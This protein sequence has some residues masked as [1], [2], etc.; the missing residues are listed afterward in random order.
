MIYSYDPNWF[1]SA[2]PTTMTP[3]EIFDELYGE[4]SRY[5]PYNPNYRWGQ[6]N[7]T[8]IPTTTNDLYQTITRTT[9]TTLGRGITT[10]GTIPLYQSIIYEDENG[11]LHGF[12][13]DG[14]DLIMDADDWY[15]IV[16]GGAMI[17]DGVTVEIKN[18][19][20]IVSGREGIGRVLSGLKGRVYSVN[21]PL[22]QE[23]STAKG[24]MK[25]QLG[26][27]YLTGGAIAVYDVIK[28]ANNEYNSSIDFTADLLRDETIV[29]TSGG[30]GIL[31]TGGITALCG[32]IGGT[33][34]T[35]AGP[36]GI[37]GGAGIGLGVGYVI[38]R[39]SDQI[40]NFWKG[41]VSGAE[42]AI[43]RL[44]SLVNSTMSYIMSKIYEEYGDDLGGIHEG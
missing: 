1:N 24:A 7:S 5:N 39:F 35:L 21:N 29:I 26:G 18:G 42:N 38:S 32:K 19:K 28:A 4:D 14:K 13:Y 23:F 22:I 6:S 10:T 8:T 27:L 17:A 12:I 44:D 15:E 25:G 2:D 9:T 3:R 43:Y 11:K 36:I 41:I 30:M 33:I 40:Y 31:A 34:G 20:A 37:I 16:K